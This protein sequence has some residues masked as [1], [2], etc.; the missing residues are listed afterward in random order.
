MTPQ[1]DTEPYRL[2]TSEIVLNARR[3][4]ILG[5]EKIPVSCPSG[6]PWIRSE[7]LTATQGKDSTG[8]LN[9]SMLW[10]ISSGR[11]FR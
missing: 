3:L 7:S 4:D 9:L 2:R 8:T 6:F 1:L 5:T 10:G 11:R